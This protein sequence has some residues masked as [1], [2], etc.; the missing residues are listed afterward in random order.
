M[1]EA[2]RLRF[3]L[4]CDQENTDAAPVRDG[5][6]TYGEK[7]LHRI[8]K[9]YANMGNA[10]FEVAVG[11][12]IADVLEGEE[13]TEIQTGSFYSLLPKLRYY[14]EQTEYRITVLHPVVAD[15]LLLRIDPD[16]GE[17]LRKRHYR[18]DGRIEEVLPQLYWLREL[19]PS[20]RISLRILLI[21]AEE[22][23]YSERMRY[24]REGAY[25]AE[26]FAKEL[27]DDICLQT[28]QD[29]ADLLPQELVRFE[30]AEFAGL[31]R[32]KSRS[33]N[34]AL[35]ALCAMGLLS[36]Q[37]DGKKFIYQTQKLS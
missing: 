24:R 12:Y 32:M 29:Y 3:R 20:S 35:Q 13:L 14:L 34:A 2:E 6:G 18:Q 27:L 19:L 26:L 37:K 7:Q 16:T 10:A 22:H 33:A 4:L 28:A 11:K 9:R 31:L 15:R 1:T 5:I 21:G 30:A 23:R 36:R 8:L 25:E 17:I